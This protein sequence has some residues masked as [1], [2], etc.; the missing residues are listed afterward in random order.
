MINPHT[1]AFW[2]VC[3]TPTATSLRTGLHWRSAP[4]N[5]WSEHRQADTWPQLDHF[6]VQKETRHD[7]NIISSLWTLE[8]CGL[9][10]STVRVV[11]SHVNN[12]YASSLVHDASACPPRLQPPSSALSY[13]GGNPL[14]LG[15]GPGTGHQ[16]PGLSF[17]G[18]AATSRPRLLSPTRTSQKT[19][20][21]QLSL[22]QVTAS[23]SN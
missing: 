12:H 11:R 2:G 17:S 1:R 13:P 3:P 15:L 23:H 5:S 16:L 14:K 18:S 22:R 8:K 20:H 9:D 7:K 19:V 4:Y 6:V 21:G 10:D